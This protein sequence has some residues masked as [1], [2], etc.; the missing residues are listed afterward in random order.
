[1]IRRFRALLNKKKA[2]EARGDDRELT[3]HKNE[4]EDGPRAALG[5]G[6][7]RRISVNMVT[8][9]ES[10]REKKR[11]LGDFGNVTRSLETGLRDR[12]SNETDELNL[13]AAVRARASRW[14]CSQAPQRLREGEMEAAERGTRLI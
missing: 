6:W 12:R 1:L 14:Q 7:Q 2:C 9:H 8:R 3:T 4:V 10:I 13:V 5:T 11:R